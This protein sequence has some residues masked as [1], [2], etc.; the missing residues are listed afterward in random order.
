MAVV[1]RRLLGI[2][3][4]SADMRAQAEAEGIVY[5]TEF[6]PVTYRFS[7]TIPGR[8]SAKSEIR[9]YVGA[10]VFTSHRVLATLSTVPKQAGQAIDQRWDAPQTGAMTAVISPQGLELDLDIDRVDSSFT[11]HL[12]LEYKAAIPEDVMSRLPTRTLAFDVPV[13][14]VLRAVGVPASQRT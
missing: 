3:K 6:V 12:S 2:G 8:K 14:Y 11:G 7:G 9:S 4:L 5:L 1:L 13:G 10:L